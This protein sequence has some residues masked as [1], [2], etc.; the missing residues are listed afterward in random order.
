MVLIVG[1]GACV[2]C[3]VCYGCIAA[4]AYTHT[5]SGRAARAGEV[6]CCAAAR[7]ALSRGAVRV[8][9]QREVV[10]AL[11][12]ADDA[13]D[14]VRGVREDGRRHDPLEVVHEEG[15]GVEARVARAVAPALPV[16]RPS[17]EK[18]EAAGTAAP[19]ATE[20]LYYQRHYLLTFY[21]ARIV[22]IALVERHVPLA[23][24]VVEGA[25][26][27]RAALDGD[28]ESRRR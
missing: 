7:G 24:V 9:G 10:R 15:G 28:K 16:L 22:V 25:V 6:R 11:L 8:A 13:V 23:C 19:N 21:M 12:E 26:P 18:A 17:G 27:G 14:D 5:H 20:R 3:Y 4:E 1:G 2:V